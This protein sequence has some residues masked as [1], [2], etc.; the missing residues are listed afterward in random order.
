MNIFEIF[1]G[2]KG[3]INEENMSSVLGFLLDPVA[4]HGYG[5]EAL[6]TFLEPIE[7]DIKKLI[8]NN[9]L[10]PLARGD[11]GIRVLLSQTKRIDIEFE[12]AYVTEAPTATR[13]KR[14]LDLVVSF[15]DQESA[16][17]LVIAIENKIRADSATDEN[18]LIEEYSSLRNE[19]E[20]KIPVIFI[21]LT[22]EILPNPSNDSL[23]NKFSN[24]FS[25]FE[26]EFHNDL[27]F[28]YAWREADGISIKNNTN[29]IS[30]STIY[31]FADALLEKEHKAKINP[32][33][34]Y[35]GL[36]LRSML[37]FIE[38]NFKREDLKSESDPSGVDY[39]T[40]FLND[41]IDFFNE[42]RYLPTKLFAI[43]INSY[44]KFRLDNL[45]SEGLFFPHYVTRNRFACFASR[46]IVVP[47]KFFPGR[48]FTIRSDGRTKQVRDPSL[49]IYFNGTDNVQYPE[50]HDEWII[51]KRSNGVTIFVRTPNDSTVSASLRHL[52]DFL[53]VG[54]N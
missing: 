21:Y 4:S 12:R 22:P 45:A 32:A 2:G 10:I 20:A 17:K 5:R 41:D 46:K 24:Q 28:S 38:Q 36:L 15:Y 54:A 18:Q 31:K 23:W 40:N 48:I 35:S 3:K 51:E 52:L 44:L 43:N 53:L 27:F 49:E 19:V 8:K 42:I 37:K 7:E 6:V 25:K 26:N 50:N 1:S 11:D 29:L 47:T 9:A 13:D 39:S 14:R 33:S 16:I 30:V 34:S